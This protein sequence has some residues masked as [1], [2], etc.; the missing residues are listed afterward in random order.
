M[1]KT[2]DH[3]GQEKTCRVFFAL[4]PDAAGRDALAAWQA[5][6]HEMCGGRVMLPET[7]H[8]TLVFLGEVDAARLATLDLAARE[9][10]FRPFDLAL[11]T[12][13]Y[14]GHNHIVYASPQETPLPLADLV[15]GLERSLAKHH[16]SF[17]R[18]PYKPHVSLLRNAKW[19]DAVLP[20]MPPVRW[21]MG[22]FVLVQSMGGSGG[23]R[24]RVLAQYGA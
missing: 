4:W 10:L 6:L 9:V 14:W 23:P 16:F 18:R 13:S 17:A 24:Y 1:L 20:V 11:T 7:L 21:H 12:V 22:G 19:N 3:T 2:M 15:D 5:P 8:V